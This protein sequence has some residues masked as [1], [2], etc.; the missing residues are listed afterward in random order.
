MRS[1]AAALILA[2]LAGTAEADMLDASEAAVLPRLVDRLCLDLDPETGCETVLLLQDV[3]EPDT[4]DLVILTDRRSGAGAV[5]LAIVRGIVF[6]GAMWGMTPTLEAGDSGAL[7]LRSE[8]SGI[9]RHPWFQA[10]T[11]TGGA[12][13]LRVVAFDWSS[14]DRAMGGAF[15][16]TV[17]LV[18]G[19]FAMEATVIDPESEEERT[20]FAETG[21]VDP[22]PVPL[23][24][25][26]AFAPLPAPCDA[27]A[28]RY[29]ARE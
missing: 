27:G 15:T 25:W 21:G 29:A 18:T 12:E 19:A 4:A 6:S 24:D 28:A 10:L 8:Q 3:A 7:I 2:L 26:H 22:G 11:I 23:T 13:G 5:P 1:E 14:Y 20:L 17:D 16:C 9:G